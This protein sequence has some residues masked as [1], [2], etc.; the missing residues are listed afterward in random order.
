M[1]RVDLRPSGRFEWAP[2]L[3]CAYETRNVNYAALMRPSGQVPLTRQ[4]DCLNANN[5][6]VT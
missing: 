3:V 6:V 1:S 4:F 2:I 5:R